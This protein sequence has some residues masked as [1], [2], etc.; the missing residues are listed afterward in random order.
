M[1]ENK[2][3]SSAVAQS[4][5]RL[6]ASLEKL[7]HLAAEK[8]ILDSHVQALETER[9]QLLEERPRQAGGGDQDQ[10]EMKALRETWEQLRYSV[11]SILGG[12]RE[13]ATGILEV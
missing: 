2:E 10:E 4:H 9:T 8:K 1:Q 6:E 12:G 13:K 7:N 11:Q 5:Q 3:L